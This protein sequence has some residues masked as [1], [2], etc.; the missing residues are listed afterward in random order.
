M[1]PD[2]DGGAAFDPF[3]LRVAIMP[4]A[5]TAGG[6]AFKARAVLAQQVFVDGRAGLDHAIRE[7][8]EELTDAA[9]ARLALGANV[10]R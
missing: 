6:R 8:L 10:V 4:P 7:L 1:D 5:Q 2:Q 3:C 9:Q